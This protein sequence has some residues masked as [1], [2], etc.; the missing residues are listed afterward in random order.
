M[1]CCEKAKHV[2]KKAG[3]IAEGF[4][5]LATDTIG[6]TEKYEFTDDRVRICQKC[7]RNQWRGRTLWCQ[8]CGCFVPAKARVTAETCPLG[9]WPAVTSSK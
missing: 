5:R 7:D 2:V 8:E 9:L 6:I 1:T 3:H 4:S